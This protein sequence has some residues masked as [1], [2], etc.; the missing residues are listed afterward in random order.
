MPSIM[1]LEGL[2]APTAEHVERAWYKINAL[3]AIDYHKGGSSK[4]QYRTLMLA[5]D[6][7]AGTHAHLASIKQ[8]DYNANPGARN[9]VKLYNEENQRF[10]DAVEIFEN[11]Y[12]R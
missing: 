10:G 11:S 8:A 5:K 4:D 6:L 12:L 9:L 2:E 7:I 1:M 3:K